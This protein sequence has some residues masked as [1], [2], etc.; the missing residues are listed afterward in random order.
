[1]RAKSNSIDE[2]SAHWEWRDKMSAFGGLLAYPSFALECEGETQGLMILSLLTRCRLPSQRGKHQVYVEFLETAPWNRPSLAGAPRYRGV[3]PAL[4]HVAITLS[5]TEGYKGRLGLH[6]L[7]QADA[8]YRDRC[9]MTDLGIDRTKG[10]R[11][12]E[13]SPRQAR[14]FLNQR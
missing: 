10:L 2:E 3:G 4:V 13:M 5:V 9:G 12:F 14:S 11:Y 6:S 8:W 7:P 1:M